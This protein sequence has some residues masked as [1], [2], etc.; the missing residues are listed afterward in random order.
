M[1]ESAQLEKLLNFRK[2]FITKYGIF[3]IDELHKKYINSLVL[4]GREQSDEDVVYLKKWMQLQKGE[5]LTRLNNSIIQLHFN[6]LSNLS[7][8]QE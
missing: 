1:G 8:N 7:I 6:D 5:I 3:K 2:F 4:E